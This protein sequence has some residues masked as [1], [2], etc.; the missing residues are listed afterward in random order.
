MGVY[1]AYVMLLHCNTSNVPPYSDKYLFLLPSPSH[2][3]GLCASCLQSQS[4]GYDL[5]SKYST[6]SVKSQPWP[7]PQTGR[8]SE[9]M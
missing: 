1:V 4:H 6:V 7:Y 2:R 3:K 5:S 9:Q 8:C